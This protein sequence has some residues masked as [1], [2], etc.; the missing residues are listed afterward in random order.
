ML[1]ATPAMLLKEFFAGRKYQLFGLPKALSYKKHS[2]A[3]QFAG[4]WVN[5]LEG[6]L[7]MSTH[8]KVRAILTLALEAGA[9]AAAALLF[10][11]KNGEELCGGIDDGLNDGVDQVRAAGK[12]L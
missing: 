11:P 3:A 8:F 4:I 5:C 10:A 12:D 2:Y 7:T 6:R 1:R 9:G